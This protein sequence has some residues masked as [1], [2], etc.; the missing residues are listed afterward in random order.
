MDQSV[1]LVLA[2]YE[3]RAVD[4]ARLMQADPAEFERRIDEFL[5]SVGPATGRSC[6]CSR[7][8]RMR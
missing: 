4:E 5:I 1:E 2:E 7:A 6:I 8:A 3:R